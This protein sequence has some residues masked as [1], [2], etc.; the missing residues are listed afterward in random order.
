[1]L[2]E[3]CKF[4][5]PSGSC[6]SNRVVPFEK[7]DPPIYYELNKNQHPLLWYF[8]TSKFRSG[9]SVKDDLISRIEFVR[10]PE[11]SEFDFVSKLFQDC[12]DYTKIKNQLL[13]F[14]HVHADRVGKPQFEKGLKVYRSTCESVPSLANFKIMFAWHGCDIAR[15]HNICDTKITK[16]AQQ[17]DPG[18]FGEACYLT[19]ELRY[20]LRYTKPND[21]GE[22]GV[23]LFACECPIY[24]YVI[25]AADYPIA[26]PPVRDHDIPYGF[27]K[28]FGR[29][30]QLACSAHWV[31]VKRFDE[32]HNHLHTY[33]VE[34]NDWKPYSEITN[35]FEHT[36]SGKVIDGG[37]RPSLTIPEK[38]TDLVQQANY[39]EVG[40]GCYQF[41][42]SSSLRPAVLQKNP[43][44]HHHKSS[45]DYP[46]MLLPKA[47]DYQYHP[48]DGCQFH[49][50]VLKEYMSF[51]I[52]VVYIKKAAF[53]I[54]ARAAAIAAADPP[55]GMLKLA[56]A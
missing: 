3:T 24:P 23:I 15:I 11:S 56:I 8:V 14:E 10:K 2:L 28:F 16:V 41:Q 20:A 53:E 46:N 27:S 9:F 26:V 51:P 52:A 43:D 29:Q 1:L 13:S 35:H 31:S 4:P 7:G 12:R 6:L 34:D 38:F 45:Y 49:E 48:E 17:T 22:V 47:F 21:Q 37:I 44:K 32:N 42:S 40:G 18:Y 19:P 39:V 55:P 36:N 33:F 25:T 54:A 30:M 5:R 50:L